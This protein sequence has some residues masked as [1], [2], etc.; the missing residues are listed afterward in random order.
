MSQDPRI[1]RMAEV[2]VRYSLGVQPGWRVCISS[3]PLAAPLIAAVYRET[4]AAA[5]PPSISPCR[6]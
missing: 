3:N 5:F 1:A 6:N 4:L 2:L